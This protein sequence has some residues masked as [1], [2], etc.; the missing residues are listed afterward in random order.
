MIE[1]SIAETDMGTF[2]CPNLCPKFCQESSKERF[3]FNLSILY[4]GLTEEERRLSSKYP[5]KM[6]KAYK[7]TRKAEKLC[8]ILYKTSQTNDESDACRHFVWSALLYNE[9]G[10]KFSKK[11]LNAHEKDPKQPL[12]E[13][14]M[15]LANNRLALAEAKKL[16][17]KKNLNNESLLKSFQ[18]NLKLKKLIILEQLPDNKK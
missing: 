4:P 7:L 1:C 15:D 10:L 11:V 16:K 17:K 3:L 18:K 8:L 13:K 6:L 14:T 2:H 9:F 12:Q 5:K